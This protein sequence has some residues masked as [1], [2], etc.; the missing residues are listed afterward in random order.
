MTKR[1]AAIALTVVFALIAVA[2]L[3]LRSERI[4]IAPGLV[5]EKGMDSRFSLI[6]D[7]SG[8]VYVDNVEGWIVT[9]RF[10]LGSLDKNHYFAVDRPCR[11]VMKFDSMP[12]FG[13]WLDSVGAKYRY[14]DEEGTA[15][16]FVDRDEPRFINVVA[17][18]ECRQP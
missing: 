3:L 13:R 6:D 1:K 4:A 11:R 10:V 15:N 9:P 16:V 8:Q 17:S 7:S 2:Y 12:E 14:A 5:V 18:A